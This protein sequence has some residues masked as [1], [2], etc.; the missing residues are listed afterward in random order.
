MKLKTIE[1]ST[2]YADRL[3][4]TLDELGDKATVFKHFTTSSC[5]PNRKANDDS[6]IET[7]T[8]YANVSI[9]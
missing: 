7:T 4:K 6:K 2:K 5:G 1:D 3:L 8:G 9:S